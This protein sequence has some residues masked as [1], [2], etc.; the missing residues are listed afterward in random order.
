MLLCVAVIHSFLTVSSVPLHEYT[1]YIL[2][3]HSPADRRLHGFRFGVF[4][5]NAAMEAYLQLFKRTY[6]FIS[7]E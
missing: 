5:N 2:F 7:L 4:M 1:Y 3:V 6:I